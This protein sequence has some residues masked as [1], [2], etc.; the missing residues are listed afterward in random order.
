MKNQIELNLKALKVENVFE[1]VML[2]FLFFM[3][4]YNYIVE[5][6]STSNNFI[7]I[8]AKISKIMRDRGKCRETLSYN[9]F[10][11]IISFLWILSYLWCRFCR[12]CEL[13]FFCKQT[14]NIFRRTTDILTILNFFGIFK[15]IS[16][17]D[18]KFFL[19][20]KQKTNTYT[21]IKNT[22]L[23]TK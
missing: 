9:F 17:D 15:R 18:K 7:R 14:L 19:K 20:Q 13:L 12:Q 8:F 4:P 3:A 2:C 5:E 6:K 1:N 22:T 23:L 16:K 10:K 11:E 21:R